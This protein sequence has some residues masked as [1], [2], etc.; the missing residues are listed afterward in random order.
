V[1][2]GKG[3][4]LTPSQNK[5]G[6][7]GSKVKKKKGGKN[8]RIRENASQGKTSRAGGILL[9]GGRESYVHCSR[10]GMLSRSSREERKKKNTT[11]PWREKDKFYRQE[12]K[13]KGTDLNLLQKRIFGLDR[14]G[15]KIKNMGNFS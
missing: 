15:G 2:K 4:F 11:S 14:G 7:E 8:S 1:G 5:E 6:K 9:V 12:T 3:L 10:G 13:G